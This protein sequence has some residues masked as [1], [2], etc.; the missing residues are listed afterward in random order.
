MAER[1]KA[2]ADAAQLELERTRAAAA[3]RSASAATSPRTTPPGSQPPATTPTPPATTAR[4]APAPSPPPAPQVTAPATP[5]QPVLQPPAPP[6]IEIPAP[7]R[8]Q[9]PAVAVNDSKPAAESDDDAVI[10]GVVASYARAIESKD[11]VLFRSLKPNMAADEE[12]RIQQ[13]FRAVTSQKV[14]VTILSID[15]RGDRATVQLKRQDVI[16]AGGRRQESESRQT[17]TMARQQ[18]TWVI[19]EIGR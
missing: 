11:L 16:E 4:E 1:F 10:R 6:R 12:R 9:P 13:G 5:Q 19:L 2:Q 3:S 14:N 15:R 18:R 7:A 17:M 8:P